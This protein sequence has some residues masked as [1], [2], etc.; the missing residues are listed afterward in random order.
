MDEPTLRGT[1]AVLRRRRRLIVLCV[2]VA[3]AAALVLSL[4]QTPRY[5]ARTDLLLK[6][7]E[8]EDLLASQLGQGRSGADASRDL[9]NE[10]R[11]IE[12]GTV[13]DAVADAYD[14]PLR[15]HDVTASAPASDRSDVIEIAMTSSDAKE[16]TRLVNLYAKTYIDER[17]RRA[18]GDM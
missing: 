12:S 7:S 4:V 10:I 6:R 9:N 2:L 11:L 18:V 8:S 5:R 15:V 16:A 17:R 3:T 13:R 14:G 1:L